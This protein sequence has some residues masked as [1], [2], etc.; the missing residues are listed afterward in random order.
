MYNYVVFA[1][2]GLLLNYVQR[3]R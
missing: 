1:P 2:V 3:Y